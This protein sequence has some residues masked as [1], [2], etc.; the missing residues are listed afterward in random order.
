MSDWIFLE[1]HRATKATVSVPPHYTSD[2]SYGCNGLFRFEMDGHLIRCVASDGFGW[3]HVSVSLENERKCP[4]WK[5]MCAV[6]DLFWDEDQVVVQFHPKK[7]DYVNWHS[8]CLHLWQ[9]L[10]KEFPIPEPILVGPKR[11]LE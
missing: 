11:S 5:I 9:C 1:K 7:K 10:D 2:S 6:K 4:T 8:Y 3:K